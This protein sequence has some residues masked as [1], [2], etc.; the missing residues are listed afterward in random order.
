MGQREEGRKTALRSIRSNAQLCSHLCLAFIVQYFFVII[1][2]TRCVYFEFNA[3]LTYLSHCGWLFRL[4]SIWECYKQCC[5][6]HSWASMILYLYWCQR[7]ICWVCISHTQIRPS[8]S[9]K[10]CVFTPRPGGQSSFCSTVF[11]T[12]ALI[13]CRCRF[14]SLQFK[15]NLHWLL[16]GLPY[17]I[18]LIGYL[19]IIWCIY[20]LKT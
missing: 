3:T 11:P 16:I 6:D 12:L 17:F 14:I 2:I 4:F 1:H 20:R 7:E 8:Y 15:M 13:C 5:F 18:C 19:I 9:P 10:G